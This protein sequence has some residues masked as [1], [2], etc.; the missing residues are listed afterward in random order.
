MLIPAR[1]RGRRAE[2]AAGERAMSSQTV[3]CVR[4][5]SGDA[6]D[7]AGEELPRRHRGDEHLDDAVV[8]L[9][10]DAAHD[11]QPVDERRDEQQRGEEEADEEVRRRRLF[12]ARRSSRA[13]RPR[14]ATS[15]VSGVDGVGIDA[16]RGEA[17]A[18]DGA[19]RDRRR[20]APG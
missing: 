4:P 13:A 14:L 6:E 9:L 18:L 1:R 17:V 2:V 5:T 20:G 15:R 11:L 10:D 12:S 16:A 8:L 3:T 19:V 7:L